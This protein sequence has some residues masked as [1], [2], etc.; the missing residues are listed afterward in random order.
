M[1]NFFLF[2]II[3]TLY[4]DA[5]I[6]VIKASEHI[7]YKAK[8][9]PDKV[10]LE[11][12]DNVKRSCIPVTKK[13]IISNE[14]RSKLIMKKGRIIC[15]KDVYVADKNRIIFD[16]GGIEIEKDGKVIRETKDYIKIRKANGKFETIRKDGR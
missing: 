6:L 5:S 9:T 8:I 2:V 15:K 1:R 4:L 11:Y 12:V 3:S 10:R 14:Y 16:F 7:K 13:E